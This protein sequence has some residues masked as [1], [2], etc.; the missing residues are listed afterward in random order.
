M[1]RTSQ[2]LAMFGCWAV[3]LVA[4]AANPASKQ[5]YGPDPAS[6]E[7]YGPAYRYPQAGWI[8]LHIEGAPYERGYQHGRLLAPEIAAYIKTLAL[9]KSAKD[10]RM[11]WD[12]L[13]SMTNAIFV[14][15]YDPEYLEEMKGIADGAAAGGAKFEGR[16]L[17]F[18]DLV[19]VNSDVE[20]EFI[21][22]AL[23][24]TSNGLE[25]KVFADPHPS[26]STPP[27]PEHC[28][29]F[30][31]N[32]KATADGS[33]VFGHITMFNLA[34][35]R[36]FNIW[37]DVKPK[38]GH[39]VLMQTYP[40][41]I[42]SGM[43]Y[44]LN[45]A[46]MI[47]AET[48]INQTKFNI[49][50]QT[51]A[52]RI[53]RVMQYSDSIDDAVRILKTANNG[54]YT[55]EWL[56]AD[57]KTN[58]IAM[59]ELGTDKSKLWRSSQNEWI[60]GTE[61]FYWGCNNAKDLDVRLETIASLEGKPANATFKPSD[62]DRTWIRLYNQ[63]KGKIDEKF[64]F[65]AFTTPPLAAFSSCDAKFTTTAMAK[66]LKT[67]A[68]FGPPLGR[69]WDPTNSQRDSY[70]DIEPLVG[71]DW[72]VLTAEPPMALDP[73][74]KAAVDLASTPSSHKPSQASSPLAGILPPA[75]HGT[76]LPASDSDI[77]LAAAFSDFEKIV[78]LERATSSTLAGDVDRR[79]VAFFVPW[80]KY[81]FAVKRLG[82]DIPLK[83]IQADLAT[84]EWHDI[85]GGK[86]VLLLASLRNRLG[87]TEFDRFMD[88]FGRS[89][90][91]KAVSSAEFFT[92]AAAASTKP[93]ES[94][95][96][97]W[98]EKS[99]IPQGGGIQVIHSGKWSIDSF[100]TELDRT[101]IVYGT[102]KER[103]AQSEAAGRLQR[104]I[105]RRWSNYAIPIKSDNDV[106]VEE[107]KSRHVV[108][109]GRPDTNAVFAKLGAMI[110]VGYGPNSFV[111]KEHTYAHPLSGVIAASENPLNS[112]YS[113]V[114]YSGLSATGIWN[115]VD[116]LADRDGDD[117]TEVLLVPAGSSPIRQSAKPI[118]CEPAVANL[119]QE[120]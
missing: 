46:G 90:A 68:L 36:H 94:F 96:V 21:D 30:A 118:V 29:A 85:A 55:N 75:W 65:M 117:A 71:N 107:L 19:T 89:H 83:E 69:T 23:N 25:S 16:S 14:R 112:R 52:S 101:I 91:G 67:H 97:D 58:E 92:A 109:I 114:A 51:L 76:I 12:S 79:E 45:D 106:T 56:L 31:A 41:G 93:L 24:A 8:V 88:K 28:S 95:F 50:G 5:E 57:T 82:H 48:T 33:I 116:K 66:E 98:F 27:P 99:G 111:F 22:S 64:G 11:G 38:D 72:T 78:A 119:S 6:V 17:D 61:G 108:L 80:T 74:S 43:D 42:Q 40:G 113:V 20:L 10:P 39:R 105:M 2:R 7:R 54:L 87:G 70:P 34:V 60:G 9:K 4:S 103:S 35:V 32:G 47:V 110:P 49:N 100:E 63:N 1:R 86:G 120:K 53:R 77:W 102:L 26:K 84:D 18:L 13:R 59:F 73:Q 104:K 81:M 62:R 37:L 15:K 44:Y 3:V 115:L